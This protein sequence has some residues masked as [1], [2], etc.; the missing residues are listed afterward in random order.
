MPT[1]VLMCAHALVISPI[2]LM[3]LFAAITTALLL[4]LLWWLGAPGEPEGDE[5]QAPPEPP[6]SR[7]ELEAALAQARQALKQALQH[8]S[9]LVR[10]RERETDEAAR[11]HQRAVLAERDGRDSLTREALMR[12]ADHERSA[13][14]LT[15]QLATCRRAISRH[16]EAIARLREQLAARTSAPAGA[17][18]KREGSAEAAQEALDRGEELLDR[19]AQLERHLD[20]SPGRLGDAQVDEGDDDDDRP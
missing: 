10:A 1:T 15:H 20:P 17:G 16:R 6:P 19:L 8:Q 14:E 11:W 18:T 7:K 5:E 9:E 12:E 2:T 13:A 4:A 3:L